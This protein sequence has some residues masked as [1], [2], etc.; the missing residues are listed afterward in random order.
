MCFVG[1]APGFVGA[2]AIVADDGTLVGVHETPTVRVTV[3]RG[4][5]QAYDLPG[6]GCLLTPYEGNR[7]HAFLAKS[8]AVPG[9]GTCSMFTIGIGFGAWL[10]L[11]A[12][13]QI[14]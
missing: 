11:P 10:A 8:Q 1:I 7:T 6:M 9:Q 5:R 4:R 3:S 2:V 13:W 14:P 12:A